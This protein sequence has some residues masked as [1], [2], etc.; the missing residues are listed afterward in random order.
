V[1]FSKTTMDKA[2]LNKLRIKAQ[3]VFLWLAGITALLVVALWAIAIYFEKDIEA[4]FLSKLNQEL[5]IRVEIKDVTFSLLKNFP[6]ASVSLENVSAD[7]SKPFKGAGKLL[8]AEHIDF[9]FSIWNLISGDYQI[10]KISIHN[11]AIQIHRDE[12]KIIN[13]QFLKEKPKAQNNEKFSFSLNHVELYK[14]D[15][16]IDDSPSKFKSSFEMNSCDFAGNF[17]EKTFDLKVSGSIFANR[18]SSGK[19]IYLQDRPVDLELDLQ[20]DQSQNKYLIRKSL[21]TVSAMEITLAGVYKD[22]DLP[23]LDM[24]AEG[25]ELDIESILSLLP[26][27]YDDKIKDYKSEGEM[28]ARCRIKGSFSEELNPAVR[29][30]FGL[31]NAT[32]ENKKAEIS[33]ENVELDGRYENIFGGKLDL[34]DV[35]FNLNGGNFKGSAKIQDFSNPSFTINSEANLNLADVN[36]FVSTGVVSNLSGNANLKLKMQADAGSLKAFDKGGY[37][38]IKANGYI[39]V[40]NGGFKIKGDTLNYSRFNGELQFQDN[41][42][43]VEQLQGMLGKTDFKLKGSLRNLFG[44]LF[45]DNESIGIDAVVESRSVYLDELFERKSKAV[46]DNETYKFKISPRL[47]LNVRAKV[48]QLQFR[49]F[50]AS[51]ISGLFDV[52]NAQLSAQQLNFNTMKGVVQMS[53]KAISNNS[54]QLLLSCKAKLT[55]VD[56]NRLFYECENFGQDVVMD[57]NIR[58]LVDANIDFEA[59]ATSTLYIDPNL[60][61]SKADLTINQGQLLRFEPLEALSKFISLDELMNVKFSQ[62]KNTIEIR[63]SKII[64]PQMDIASSA[65]TISASGIHSFDNIIEYHLKLLLSDILARKAKKARKDIEEFGVVEDDGLGKTSLFIAMKGPVSNPEISYDSQG[66]RAKIK[67]D[68]VNEKQT[69]KQLLKEEFGLFKKDST[70]GKKPA[71]KK[72]QSK[73]IISFDEEEDE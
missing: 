3:K 6:S 66:A 54:D 31:K 10:E 26:P 9:S 33:L 32:I 73:V 50:T 20:I 29:I 19:Q 14:M 11:G 39:K 62:L 67:N 15:F 25:E 55:K 34:N 8:I 47:N 41:L 52:S 45:G 37:N 49:K 48:N 57:E 38:Q 69:M 16:L 36:R 2:N 30:D 61:Y 7:H 59:I 22:Q 44:W 51:S 56:I 17:N 35:H 65:I 27:G 1:Y 18:I 72:K 28:Y 63:N 43:K 40:E 21:V 12:N 68:I 42:V 64:I 71:E 13:Y 5:N 70:L 58:G 46:G 60:V 53:G 4:Y 24:E 23:Y